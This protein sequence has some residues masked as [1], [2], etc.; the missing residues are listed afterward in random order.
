MLFKG[1]KD[2]KQAARIMVF[3]QKKENAQKNIKILK[4]R[5]GGL[6]NQLFVDFCLFWRGGTKRLQKQGLSMLV[7]YKP[8]KTSKP[9]LR[10]CF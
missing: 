8:S 9:L 3:L 2:K 4:G 1:F 6:G 5:V 7:S 10:S